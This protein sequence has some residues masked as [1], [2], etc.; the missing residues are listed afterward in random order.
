MGGAGEP[1]GL[2]IRCTPGF[3]HPNHWNESKGFLLYLKP[4]RVGQREQGH[5]GQRF[6]SCACAGGA[7]SLP[8]CTR[9]YLP[10]YTVPEYLVQG[11][12]SLLRFPA[13]T[14]DL[15]RIMKQCLPVFQRK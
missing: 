14:L 4:E 2:R 12:P 1:T 6:G 9:P 8:P 15:K 5:Q 10:L 3:L 7:H 13:Q 11:N